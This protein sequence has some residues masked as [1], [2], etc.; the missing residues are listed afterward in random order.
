MKGHLYLRGTTWWYG[1][2]L[3][4][5][6][7]YRRSL[8]TADRK[9][10]EVRALDHERAVL[11]GVGMDGSRTLRDWVAVWLVGVQQRTRPSTARNYRRIAE[12]YVLPRIGD[13][14]L[15]AL[16]PGQVEAMDH[17]LLRGG[18][19]NGR[20]LDPATVRQ[21]HDMLASCLHEALRERHIAVNVAAL[22]RR[23]SAPGTP[24]RFLDRDEA[25]RLMD[26]ARGHDWGAYAAVALLTGLRAGELCGLRWE[27]VTLDRE[28]GAGTLRVQR[29][30]R[31]D[32][33]ERGF[34]DAPP[35]SAAG[36]R[37]IPLSE[38]AVT[39]LGAL[40]DRRQERVRLGGAAD[41]TW[42]FGHP[43]RGAERGLWV[44]WTPQAAAR[45]VGD[46]YRAAGLEVPAR[47][48]HAL[49]HT[50]GTLLADAREDPKV[51]AA[52]L[53]HSRVTV[54]YGYTHL[55]A[56]TGKRAMDAVGDALSGRAHTH[57]HAQGGA[58]TDG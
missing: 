21:C 17:D 18:G 8:E 26:A 12:R 4:Q 53:G 20:A 22:A 14:R 44:P 45:G 30:R 9:V 55:D 42:V 48:I 11:T 31:Y 56:S 41:G 3:P 47:P 5:G 52:L 51:R 37:A 46:L 13:T 38:A 58:N 36:V 10:A 24:P 50:C 40:L 33:P 43:G 1:A 39:W 57:A 23:P 25:L 28:S 19:R 27:D 6:K 29:Q 16:T 49:R 15:D 32:G 34:V 7:Q 35:K 2:S 54:T